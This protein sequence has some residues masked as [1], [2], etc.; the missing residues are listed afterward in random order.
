MTSPFL[1][2]G[3]GY[4]RRV[5]DLADQIMTAFRVALPSN[6]V[7]RVGGPLYFNRFRALAT[8]LARLQISMSDGVGDLD[9]DFTRAEVLYQFL[10]NMAVPRRSMGVVEGVGDVDHRDFLSTLLRAILSGA[11]GSTISSF[12][13]GLKGAEVSFFVKGE[14]LFSPGSGWGVEDKSGTEVLVSFHDRTGPGDGHSHTVVVD[15]DGNGKTSS[16]LGEYEDHEHT[17][18]RFVVSAWE[19]HSHALLDRF[20]D[21]PWALR[22]NVGMAMAALL[23]AQAL[24]DYR[25][26]FREFAPEVS[27]TLSISAE[28][29]RYEDSRKNWEGFKRVSGSGGRVTADRQFLLDPSRT[30]D[31]VSPGSP[32]RILSGPNAGVW[33]VEAVLRVPVADPSL[34]FFT[35]SP[36]DLSGWCTVTAEGEA[37]SEDTDFSGI[38]EDELLT[39]SSGPLSGTWRI[40][41]VLGNGGGFAGEAT[42]SSGCTSVLLSNSAVKVRGKLRSAGVCPYEV[43]LDRMGTKTP[44]EETEDVSSQFYGDGGDVDFFFVSKGPLS[45]PW[46]NARLAGKGDVVVLLDGVEKEVSSLFPLSGKVELASPISSFPPGDRE[47]VVRYF[48]VDNPVVPIRLS[49]PGY[50]LSSWSLPRGRNTDSVDSPT[51]RRLPQRFRSRQTIGTSYKRFDPKRVAHRYLGTDRDFSAPLSTPNQLRLSSFFP[52]LPPATVDTPRESIFWGAGYPEGWD[53]HGEIS[54]EVSEEGLKTGFSTN[55]VG[56]FFKPVRVDF[57]RFHVCAARFRVTESGQGVSRLAFGFH[58]GSRCFLAS[59]ILHRGLRHLGVL[60]RPGDQESVESWHLGPVSPSV[61]VSGSVLESPTTTTP[62][63]LSTGSR[64]QVLGGP[65]DGVY[66]VV[67]VS[68]GESKTTVVV[69]PEFP[70]DP[71]LFGSRDVEVRWEFDW[72]EASTWKLSVDPQVGD[73]RLEVSSGASLSLLSLSPAL[74]T[75]A[76]LFPDLS[77][78]SPCFFWGSFS[79]GGSEAVWDFVS[80]ESGA[81]SGARGIRVSEKA[82]SPLS[83]DS[84]ISSGWFPTSDTGSVASGSLRKTSSHPGAGYGFR[85]SDPTLS[86][87]RKWLLGAVFSVPSASG[88]DATLVVDDGSRTATLSTLLVVDSGASGKSLSF[89]AALSLFGTSRPGDQGWVSEGPVPSPMGRFLLGSTE[90][91]SPWS[92]SSSPLSSP[93][94]KVRVEVEVLSSTPSGD[95]RIGLSVGVSMVGRRIIVDWVESGFSLRASVSTAPVVTVPTSWDGRRVLE[96]EED[97]TDVLFSLDGSTIATEALSS[98]PTDSVYPQASLFGVTSGHSSC[99]FRVWGATVSGR[100]PASTLKTMGVWKGG[101]AGDIDSWHIP[102]TD[103]TESANSSP[104]SVFVEWDYSSEIEVRAFCDPTRGVSVFRPDLPPPPGY[105]G[106]FSTENL[107]EDAA[108]L[109]VAY[110]DLPRSISHGGFF[111]FGTLPETGVSRTTWGDV[112]ARVFTHSSDDYTVPTPMVL[113]RSHQVSSGELLLDTDPEVR[114]ITSSGPH[115]L[116]LSHSFM[117]ASRVLRVRVAGEDV[118]GWEFDGESQSLVFSDPLPGEFVDVEVSFLPCAPVSSTYLARQPIHRSHHLLGEGTPPFFLGKISGGDWRTVSGDSFGDLSQDPSSPSYFLRDLLLR[119]RFYDGARGQAKRVEY[120]TLEDGVSGLVSTG[121]DGGQ[122]QSVSASGST[123]SE[124]WLREPPPAPAFVIGLTPLGGETGVSFSLSPDVFLG[125]SAVYA[126][127][128]DFVD[129]GPVGWALQGPAVF[130]RIG[131]WDPFSMG[132][133]SRLMGGDSGP[134]SGW[135]LYGGDA[136]PP[137]PPVPTSGTV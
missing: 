112:V 31:G 70:S 17:I 104:S 11:R 125:V 33:D 85:S 50:A 95:G 109:T 81:V 55:E 56:C 10:G 66:S 29:E 88:G 91:R 97:G 86:R 69:S 79:R 36:S 5:S 100:P 72:R 61:V 80:Y 135:V 46:G 4:E 127:T 129:S 99:S 128:P 90:Y 117:R 30:F 41:R 6:Y 65:Q 26:V 60:A 22:K 68:R 53:R 102:R 15:Q 39:I 20:P 96:V 76:V 35:T 73:A 23:P 45:R 75:P 119:R 58:D 110:G 105:L 123:W 89:P 94:R 59:A 87:S 71:G 38:T 14:H 116:H 24:Y 103:G 21:L 9:L 130:S 67:S 118:A 82:A 8:E 52:L 93:R 28:I 47:V 2:S 54:W 16:V 132:D 19:S 106:R 63:S 111:Y 131:P 121:N 37:V 3:I 124:I 12:L 137:E 98:F 62:E 64:F 51:G 108:W 101:D 32:L 13:S 114:T 1:P 133:E 27:S 122:L 78:A 107:V 126:E 43:G 44:R 134:L 48:W 49:T 115:R 34:R 40:D 77:P 136:V 83:L 120:M 18:S 113:G 84:L 7:S 57:A 74:A 92:V 25:Y 42:T